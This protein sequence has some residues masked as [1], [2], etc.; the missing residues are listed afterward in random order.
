MQEPYLEITFRHGRPLAA[1]FY[2]PR[3]E[4]QSVAR[5]QRMEHGLV[6]DFDAT[7]APIGI[8][9]TAPEEITL[10][11]FNA[12][13]TKLGQAPISRDEFAPLRAA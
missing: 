9:I 4:G 13:L 7:G 11:E 12:L 3:L 8:E 5:T 2:L 6:V 10:D 1:Y